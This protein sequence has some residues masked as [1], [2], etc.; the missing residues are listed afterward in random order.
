MGPE[1]RQASI[2]Q[3]VRALEDDTLAALQGGFLAEQIL[4]VRIG[5][6]DRLEALCHL[7]LVTRSYSEAAM[8]NPQRT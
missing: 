6:V 8:A 7:L 3:A 5:T 1:Q 4:F 2:V